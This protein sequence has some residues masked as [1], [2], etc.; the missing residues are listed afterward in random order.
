MIKVNVPLSEEEFER[1]A[2]SP[3][4]VKRYRYSYRHPEELTDENLIKTYVNLCTSAFFH[5]KEKTVRSENLN[6]DSMNS[7]EKEVVMYNMKRELEEMSELASQKNQYF[8]QSSL[9]PTKT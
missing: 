1:E 2:D 3:Y 5:N 8:S 4:K 9:S 7:E 6:L